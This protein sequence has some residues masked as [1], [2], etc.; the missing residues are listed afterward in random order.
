MVVAAG[1]R[2]HIK[3]ISLFRTDFPSFFLALPCIMLESGQT[4]LILH[5]SHRKIFK[6]RVAI[7]QYY[8]WKC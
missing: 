1:L 3:P 6:V 2:V 8:A 7:F 5:C 4:Y